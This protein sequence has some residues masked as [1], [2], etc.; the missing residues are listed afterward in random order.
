MYPDS[1]YTVLLA[2]GKVSVFEVFLVHVQSKCGKYGPEKLSGPCPWHN[3]STSIHMDYTGLEFVHN[4][5]KYTG[6][7][8]GQCMWLWKKWYSTSDH[9]CVKSVRICSYSSS[10]AGKYGPV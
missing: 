5:S 1:S 7:H 3:F 9:H 10:N 6:I 2:A 4:E 8:N